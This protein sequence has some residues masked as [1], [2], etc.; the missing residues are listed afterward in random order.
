MGDLDLDEL[1]EILNA[2][3]VT[4]IFHIALQN[5]KFLLIP[6]TSVN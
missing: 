4:H 1:L 6:V 3:H 2:K 5:Y